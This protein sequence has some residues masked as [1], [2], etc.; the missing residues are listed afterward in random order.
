MEDRTNRLINEKSPYL[1]QHAH[2]PVDWHP[3][4]RE[5]FEKAE[6]ENKPV[7]LSIGYSTCHWCHVMER[8]SFEDEDV[9]ALMNSLFI[10]IKVDR[11]ERPDLDNLYMTVC[12]MLTGAGG[13]P[14]TIIM[15]PDKRPFFA[16][17][18]IPK[19]TRFGRMGLLE[20]VPRISELWTRGRRN[21]LDSADKV[22]EALKGLESP[23]PGEDLDSGV[24]DRAY[25][26]LTHSF[27]RLHGGFGS[28]PKFPSP[29][30]LLFLLRYW[31]RTGRKEAL[32][33]TAQ[34]I[35][36]M[37]QGGIYDQIGFGFH[38][39]STDREWLVPH[40]EKMLY[41]QA[42]IAIACLEVH[43]ATG[44][45]Y[46]SRIA[47]EI[48]VYIMR[49][50]TSPEGGFYSAEDADS[51]G[52][53]GRFYLWE[54]KEVLDIL[55]KTDGELFMKFFSMKKE[56]N[57]R[58]ESTGRAR[59]VNIP[60]MSNGPL[61]DMEDL[62]LNAGAIEDEIISFRQ[63]LFNVREKRPHPYKDDKILTDWNGLM[64]AALARGS[65]VLGDKTCL[66]AAVRSAGFILNYMRKPDGRLLHRYRDG[67]AA[68]PAHLDDYAFL[69]WGL[70]ELYEA[71]FDAFFLKTAMELNQ[72]MISFFWDNDKGG[73]FFT[74]SDAE[75]LLMRKKEAYDAA[76]PSGNAVAMLNILRLA[77][78]TGRTELDEKAAQ[79]G[80]AF[81][82]QVQHTPSA[83][84][85]FM[86]AVDFALGPAYEI[87]IS[88]GSG[89]S[90]TLEMLSS[91]RK[92]FIPNKSVIL[93]PMDVAE[94][95]IDNLAEFVS[96]HGSK[97]DRATAYVCLSNACKSPTTDPLEML[98]LLGV[99]K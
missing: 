9:A 15:T 43:Q 54:E 98:K 19:S 35:S 94:P 92:S 10:S 24:L 40:F 70:I 26:E 74:A 13:W 6:R 29:H 11:E 96:A 72:D 20:L 80:R 44:K 47:R 81:S 87:V 7:F 36:S 17:T 27:D 93:R 85:F 58:D 34:T 33:M 16:G 38:R 56:G 28:A 91:L 95:P 42:L 5:A 83:H 53:E 51:E 71:C 79:I 62:K 30:N 73:F 88:G 48:F 86:T 14:L 21:V 65:Q 77:R 31:K 46:Y 41:D 97:N 1:L 3:W 82:S 37:H 89:S 75:K 22:V 69:I 99:K 76:V 50:M 64:I 18:Y 45:D 57:F 4:G 67:E 59:G 63:L 55:G 61:R 60:H 32:D 2:N 52:E 23:A 25:N 68:I 84:S 12:Q 78:F 49:D 66:D 8:E 39:Y 90:D